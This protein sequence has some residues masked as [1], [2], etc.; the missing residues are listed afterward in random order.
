MIDDAMSVVLNPCHHKKSKTGS[1]AMA[2]LAA[3]AAKDHVDK[4]IVVA[5]R[6]GGEP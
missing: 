1:S 2:F 4:A 6:E 3:T 5:D